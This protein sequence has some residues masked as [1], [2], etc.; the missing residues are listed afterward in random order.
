M[1]LRAGDEAP[2]FKLSDG[3]GRVWDLSELKGQMVI[4]Y[5]YPADDTPGCTVQACD[6]RDTL[7]EFKESGYIVLGVSPQDAA[8]H[9]KFTNKFSLN[10][11]LLV[12]EDREVAL[13]YG[14]TDD[15][16]NL[17]KGIPLR[18]RRATF[19]IDEKGTL[20]QALYGVKAKGHV[21]KLKDSLLT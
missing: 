3:E 11:P 6:F 9:N 19:V 14:A 4:L 8:S 2:H 15:R 5:F 10:F 18:V 12:D 17:F 16:G 13:A 1:K 21:E 7:D 20:E